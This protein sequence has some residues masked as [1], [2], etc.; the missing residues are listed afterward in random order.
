MSRAQQAGREMQRASSDRIMKKLPLA[1]T[2]PRVR[3]MNRAASRRHAPTGIAPHGTV[4]K[5][6]DGV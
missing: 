3:L 6:W 5:I 1:A 2:S 4:A